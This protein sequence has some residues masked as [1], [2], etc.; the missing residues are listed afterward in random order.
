MSSAYDRNGQGKGKHGELRDETAL[1]ETFKISVHS[2]NEGQFSSGLS[3][4]ILMLAF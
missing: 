3:N 4:K 1:Q 2:K